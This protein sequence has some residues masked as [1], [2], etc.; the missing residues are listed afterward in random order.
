M[1]K[2]SNPIKVIGGYFELADVDCEN[3]R[4]PVE[5]IAL[6]T[7]RNALEY[8]ILQ[9]ADVKRIFIPY[10][11]CE[12]VVEPLKRLSIEYVFYHINEQLEID[13]E[14]VLEE[15]D[16][17]IANNYFGIKDAYIAKLAQKYNNRLIVDNAQALFAPIITGIKAVYST[18]KF[19]GVADGGFAFGVPAEPA[20]KYEIDNS[21]GR[22]TH[23]YIRKEKGAEAG[24]KDYQTNEC[25]L[26]NQPIKRISPQTKSVLLKIDYKLIIEKRINNFQ[27]IS[28]V[29]GSKNLLQLPSIDSF[30]C[31]MVYPF[32][33]N[34]KSLREQL[35]RNKVFVA[36]YWPNVLEWCK[37]E[38]IEYKLAAQIIPLPI[39]QRYSKSDMERILEI[40]K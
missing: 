31:P 18:R 22:D 37:E 36:R 20:L 30:V 10:F 25:K 39:D 26:E 33:T 6:N 28:N 8:I 11:T 12:A 32:M 34:D 29:L 13:E 5:G 14:L 1:V 40:I 35:I 27:F 15:G 21:I 3:G 9:L 38:D 4:M 16:Y 7:C 2:S 19:V 23:L 17:L 24:F